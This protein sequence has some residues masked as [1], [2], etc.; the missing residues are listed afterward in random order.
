M[1]FAVDRKVSELEKCKAGFL[2]CKESAEIKILYSSWECGLEKVQRDRVALL[3]RR[4]WRQAASDS[5]NLEEA[6]VCLV[7]V[8]GVP[9]NGKRHTAPRM[10]QG[11]PCG[12]WQ[13]HL[14]G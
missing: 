10:V 5:W 2:R 4:C 7:L 13:H 14:S 11:C 3:S 9:G 1:S 8:E 6:D 12:G